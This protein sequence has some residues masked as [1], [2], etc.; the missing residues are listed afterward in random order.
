M[1]IC[2]PT[3]SPSISSSAR[4]FELTLIGLNFFPSWQA[5]HSHYV[6]LLTNWSLHL[7]FCAPG[8]QLPKFCPTTNEPAGPLNRQG[9]GS[10]LSIATSCGSSSTSSEDLCHQSSL[11][12]NKQGVLGKDLVIVNNVRAISALSFHVKVFRRTWRSHTW[13]VLQYLWYPD[14]T[15]HLLLYL[16]GK[17]SLELTQTSHISI[18]SFFISDMYN[19][20]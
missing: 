5:M 2:F 19:S 6:C 20:V 7:G 3:L 18:R 12:E 4:L 8:T 10:Y 15:W 11:R 1:F 9:P 17:W 13:Q 14:E 16:W